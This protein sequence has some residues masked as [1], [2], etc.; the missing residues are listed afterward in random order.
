MKEFFEKVDFEEK[1]ICRQQ[2][3]CKITQHAN[4]GSMTFGQ[5]TFCRNAVWLDVKFG[6]Y[7][8]WLTTTFG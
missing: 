2:K 1:N 6:H 7:D 8:V 5:K 4:V 3:T